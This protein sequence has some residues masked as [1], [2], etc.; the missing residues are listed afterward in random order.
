VNASLRKNTAL[1]IVIGILSILSIVQ[2]YMIFRITYVL[3][4]DMVAV[5][6]VINNQAEALDELSANKKPSY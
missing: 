3:N 1:W 5:S 2:F 4:R 6:A